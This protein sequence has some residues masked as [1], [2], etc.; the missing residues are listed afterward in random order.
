MP[1][2]VLSSLQELCANP[3]L[4]FLDE[5]RGPPTITESGPSYLLGLP[6]P[7]SRHVADF[8]PRFVLLCLCQPPEADLGYVSACPFTMSS[9]S[10][11]TPPSPLPYAPQAWTRVRRSR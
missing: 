8:H 7:V 9:L 1:V 11:L 4:L 5:V 6:R 10:L 2:P 3:S